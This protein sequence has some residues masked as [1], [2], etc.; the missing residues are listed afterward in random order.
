[1]ANT[2]PSPEHTARVKRELKAAGTTAYGLI[3]QEA[4]YLP[5]IIHPNETIGGVVYGRVDGSSAMLIAT[6][7][8]VIFLDRKPGFTHSEEITYDV[9]AGVTYNQQG[10]F[11][12]VTLHTRLG[13]FGM[14]Y[15][16]LKAAGQFVKFVEKRQLEHESGRGNSAPI[17]KV[18]TNHPFDDKALTFLKEHDTGVLSSV[19]KDGI[20]HGAVVYYIS[21]DEGQ[22]YIVTKSETQKATDVRTV[23]RVAYTV[24]NAPMQQTLQIEGTAVIETDQKKKDWVFASIIRPRMSAKGEKLPPVTKIKDGAFVIICITPK[25]SAF[26][27][28]AEK[29]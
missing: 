14:R 26:R 12:A 24:F 16:N 6:N 9:V 20:V 25:W 23:G 1:M 8:R 17:T 4:R 3:K 7:L 5:R 18:H 10:Q 21:D 22:L 15:V 2:S 29:S 11:A 19:D 28:Y 13:D 27:D